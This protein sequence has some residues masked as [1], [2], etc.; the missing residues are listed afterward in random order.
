MAESQPELLDNVYTVDGFARAVKLTE[1]AV[2]NHIVRGTL[3]VIRTLRSR[4]VLISREA[5]LAFAK[6]HGLELA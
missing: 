4:R 3:P 1:C 5:G 2:R 6:A